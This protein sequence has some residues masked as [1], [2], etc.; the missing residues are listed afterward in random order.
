MN[1]RSASPAEAFPPAGA[2]AAA[3]EPRR[4]VWDAPVRLFHWLMVLCFAGAWLTAESEPWRL[5][6]VTLGYTMAG[7]VAFRLLWGLVGTRHARFS[8]FVR[9]PA[10]V[11]G[12]LR[13]LALGRPEHHVGHNPAGALAIVALIGLAIATTAAGWATY[14]EFGGDWLEELHEGAAT[15]MLA[16]VGLHV[17]AVLLSSVLHGE[18][19]VGAMFTGRKSAP[20]QEAI[21]T[22]WRSVAALMLVAVL[23][24]WAWQWHSAPAAEGGP[25]ATA[26][27]RPQAAGGHDAGRRG[28]HRSHDD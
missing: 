25:A 20:P 24:F 4:L 9:G 28:K 3:A 1:T 17:G 12:Y 21:R 11:L 16:L 13:S 7:L 5:L 19:L 27:G 15:A 22:A 18:N 2:D 10:A 26:E 23:G 8:R 14:N 6:H